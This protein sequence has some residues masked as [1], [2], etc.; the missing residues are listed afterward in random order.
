MPI[1]I[2]FCQ[3]TKRAYMNRY[4]FII[5]ILSIFCTWNEAQS[6]FPPET[7]AKIG[8]GVDTVQGVVKGKCIL[9][10]KLVKQH[11]GDGQ[12]M[13]YDLVEV[14]NLKDLLS[15][16]KG[17]LRV[18]F[19][20]GPWHN[21]LHFE[22]AKHN[23]LQSKSV[24]FLLK[25]K[26]IN[27]IEV[28]QDYEADT[29][30][31]QKVKEGSTFQDNFGN[32]F[33][34][35][36]ETGGEFYALLEFSS[37]SEEVLNEVRGISHNKISL[38]Q[39]NGEI[40]Q[41]FKD[42]AKRYKLAIRGFRMGGKGAIPNFA[43]IDDLQRYALQFP[44]EIRHTPIITNFLIRDYSGVKN[45]NPLTIDKVLTRQYDLNE[46]ARIVTEIVD[47]RKL[48][49][50][51]LVSSE[52]YEDFNGDSLR[53]KDKELE[54]IHN[55]ARILALKIYSG[56]VYTMENFTFPVVKLPKYKSHNQSSI[57]LKPVY[58]SANWSGDD[59]NKNYHKIYITSRDKTQVDVINTD[60]LKQRKIKGV[61]FIKLQDE[62]I[63]R[64]T[65]ISDAHK[66]FASLDV[67]YE[68]GQIKIIGQAT[69][70]EDF[71][72]RASYLIY[73]IIFCE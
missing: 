49:A 41:S 26:V 16:L 52:D 60:D 19:D 2:K 23:Y 38:I 44:E 62:E 72:E 40:T 3:I 71:N 24:Y 7:G 61:S 30:A 68:N 51:I 9:N 1:I 45:L 56:D 35:G 29:D 58:V 15:K 22:F 66:G 63:I 47:L 5:I 54:K 48:I 64:C 55:N 8:D 57:I 70:F 67:I 46:L 20:F 4:F 69:R 21:S 28:L 11:Q 34:F 59:L 73:I 39:S 31:I 10:G 32:A 36:Q 12:K 14:S 25:V 6:T 50:S 18:I 53:E 65:K 17:D 27:Q 43:N 37:D 33:V 13:F 42:I